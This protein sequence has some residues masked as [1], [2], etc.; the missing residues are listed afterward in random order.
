MSILVIQVP[1]RRRLRAEPGEESAIGPGTEFEFVLSND[2]IGFGSQGRC[3][4][5][6]LPKASSVIAV[7]SDSDVAW[8]R[9]TLPKAPAQR[10]RAAL[11]GVLEDQLIDEDVHLAVAPNAVPGQPAWI[12]AVHRPWL[13]QVLATLEKAQVFVD[14]VAPSS[15]PDDPPSG[16]FAED[17]DAPDD[18]V[19]SLVLTWAHVDGVASLKLK[20]GLARALLPFP[21]PEGVRWTATPGVAMTAGAWL[22][23]PMSVM[24]PGQRALQ[25]GRTTWN[26]RQFE[27]TPRNRGMRALRD[28]LRR[29]LSPAWRPVRVG[30]AALVAVQLLGLNLYAYGQ[31]RAVERRQA[32]MVQLLRDTFPQVR[33]VLDAPVQMQREV[34]ALRGAAGRTG[35]TDLE[36]LLQAAASAWPAARP[37]VENLR[38]EPGSLTLAAPGWTNEEIEQFRARLQPA[39]WQVESIDNRLVLRRAPAA[40]AQGAS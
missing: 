10:L 12:A 5:A 24:T 32:A 38:F 30:L 2:G 19:E 39:G 11:G 6:L 34:D 16:H 28:L 40:G 8:H 23:A 33:A 1:P 35:E 13:V 15:W 3:A 22:G 7:L 14:R 20:G 27:L 31:Q 18:S 36:P 29:V 17:A 25:A 9:I 26:L 21:L 4:A 37:A